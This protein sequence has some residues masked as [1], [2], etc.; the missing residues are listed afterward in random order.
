MTK[1][2]RKKEDDDEFG[3][4]V[5]KDKFKIE[6]GYNDDLNEFKD[7][8]KFDDLNEFKHGQSAD[9]ADIDLDEFENENE[10]DEKEEE[11]EDKNSNVPSRGHPKEEERG[12]V[13]KERF[14]ND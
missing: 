5:K 11:E 12:V 13:E 3:D 7:Q 4:G 9:L 8:P 10:D 6:F 2:K 14:E 1:R